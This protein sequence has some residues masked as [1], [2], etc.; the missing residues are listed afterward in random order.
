MVLV[1]FPHKISLEQEMQLEQEM[2]VEQVF[3]FLRKPL[4]HCSV[5]TSL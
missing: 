5:A 2:Y 1:S 4:N 3:P